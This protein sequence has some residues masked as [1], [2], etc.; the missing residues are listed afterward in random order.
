MGRNAA[1]IVGGILT[2]TGFGAPV[3]IGLIAAD[4]AMEGKLF[5][6]PGLDFDFPDPV[7]TADKDAEVAARKERRRKGQTPTNLSGSASETL[8]ASVGRTNLGGTLQA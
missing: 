8:S 1:S 7:Q 4:Q 2:A 5:E 3:G 6:P